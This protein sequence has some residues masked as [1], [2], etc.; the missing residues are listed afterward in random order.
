MSVSIHFSVP[1]A[2]TRLANMSPDEPMNAVIEGWTQN[3]EELLAIEIANVTQRTMERAY[4]TGA[5]ASSVTGNVGSGHPNLVSV[6]FNNAQ[7][8]SQWGRYYAPYQEGPPIGLSTYTNEPRHMLYDSKT[9][10]VSQIQQWAV[11]SGGSA[12]NDWALGIG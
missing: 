10:D 7:Q 11:E 12:A 3:A 4:D 5:L 8:Y 6:W 2:L 9:D 1:P